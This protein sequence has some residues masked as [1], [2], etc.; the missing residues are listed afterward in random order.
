MNLPT[1]KQLRYL[2]AL[3]E[4]LH[5]GKAAKSCFISQSGF[6]IA[7]K[8]LEEILQAQL[9]DRTNKSALNM[10]P[11]GQKEKVKSI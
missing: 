8:E 4:H 3:A 6:S 1:V 5:F 7:I 9:V 11:F 2:V 10:M